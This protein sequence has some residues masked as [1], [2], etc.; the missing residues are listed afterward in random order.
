MRRNYS[1]LATIAENLGILLFDGME[2]SK[3]F[4]LLMDL[5]INKEYKHSLKEIKRRILKGDTLYNSFKS[6]YL[7]PDLFTGLIMLGEESGELNKV[8]NSTYKYYDKLNKISK[9][10]KSATIYPIILIIVM[11]IIIII[12]VTF[13]VPNLYNILNSIT[14]T[15]PDFIANVYE[16]NLELKDNK[17]FYIS[18]FICYFLIIPIMLL[19]SLTTK[20]INSTI[21][22]K[23]R[24]V[25]Q[26]YE[27]IMI[28]ILS[29]IINSGIPISIGINTCAKKFNI[30]I[31]KI[32]LNSIN[33]KIINGYTL[34]EA[35]L[36]SGILYNSTNSLIKLGEEAG[37]LD[38]IINKLEERL[39]LNLE[40]NINKLTRRIQPIIIIIMSLIVCIFIVIFI[41]PIFDAMYIKV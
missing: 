33:D 38:K 13:I 1:D 29:V 30:K 24:I 32:E 9:E 15:I 7:F 14:V 26:I 40:N 35:F 36:E 27:Y 6:S 16:F 22:V 4:D 11:V 10:L 12:A 18:F 5:K 2:I 20:I 37:D 31:V 34:H 21:W 28:L 19:K 39:A 17:L 25:R 41:L 3:S 8:L 23:F